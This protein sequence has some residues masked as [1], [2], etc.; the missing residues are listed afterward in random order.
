MKLMIGENLR[1]LRRE[2]DI[3]QEELARILGVTYQ[4]VSRWE[5]GSCYPDLELLP[6]IAG[7]FG[8]TTD[9]LMGVS[10]TAEK[11]RVAELSEAFQEALS[12]GEVYRCIDIARTGVREYP[13]NYTLL[14]LLMY[15][16][17]LSGDGDGNIPEWR[18][19]MA[20]YDSEIVE[21]GER[22][23]RYCPDLK[24]RLEATVTLAFH[25]CEAGRKRQGRALYETL[26]SIK[27]CREAHIWWGLEDEER[28]PRMQRNMR[29]AYSIMMSA[30]Y[31]IISARLLPDED[32]IQVFQ[33]KSELDRLLTGGDS[34]RNTWDNARDDCL[35]A[36]AF[37]RLG[38]MEDA[39]SALWQAVRGVKAFDARPEV[40][41]YESLL[42]GP[43]T[44]YRNQYETTDT[45]PLREIMR[46][47]WLADPD[48]DPLRE[49]PEFR[50]ILAA[51]SEA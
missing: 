10:E 28:L 5:N 19:N 18:E 21:L 13:N 7:F 3:T 14:N 42:L 45:R 24:T 39:V 11:K 29:N 27:Q 8:V 50:E 37:A 15:A 9:K 46:D 6:A 43:Y 25:H 32:L 12:R 36:A 34:P 41:H 17:F 44:Q 38:R 4:S 48:F 20:K 22:I 16:L 30:L 2:R 49:R 35:M 40:E 31:N 51:L 47:K 1:Q 33:Q 26:P 23:I